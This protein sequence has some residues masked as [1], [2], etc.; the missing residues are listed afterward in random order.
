MGCLVDSNMPI[1]IADQELLY[2]AFHFVPNPDAIDFSRF[3]KCLM[4]QFGYTCSGL[5]GY[6]KRRNRCKKPFQCP[7][8]SKSKPLSSFRM[9]P[10][11]SEAELYAQVPISPAYLMDLLDHPL[12]ESTVPLEAGVALCITDGELVQLEG[13][14][15]EAPGFVDRLQSEAWDVVLLGMEWST[16]ANETILFRVPAGGRPQKASV[17]G[18]LVNAKGSKNMDTLRPV[19]QNCITDKG[20][21]P[22]PIF[23]A[24]DRLS[25]WFGAQKFADTVEAERIWKSMPVV[26]RIFTQLAN[27]H[28]PLHFDSHEMHGNLIKGNLDG[29]MA[30]EM[31]VEPNGSILFRAWNDNNS[32]NCEMQCN[33]SKVEWMKVFY[34]HQVVFQ[35][36]NKP[37]P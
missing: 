30:F 15:H 34:D 27:H 13:L 31:K 36:Q 7:F 29:R 3:P 33:P 23:N 17:V 24:A 26:H 16:G 21:D 12:A 5:E 9:L 28:P 14:R 19:L 22:S 35:A 37:L 4:F 20:F 18:L 6:V 2:P 8:H 10:T 25:L 1:S 32:P 11:A